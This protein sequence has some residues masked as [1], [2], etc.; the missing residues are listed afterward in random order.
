MKDL[1]ETV[2]ETSRQLK[3]D[4]RQL[5]ESI[6]ATNK[7]LAAS[8]ADLDDK[9]SKWGINYGSIAE[10]YFI[11]SFKHGK[12]N[13][14]GENFDDILVRAPGIKI[15]TDY[16]LA[17]LNGKS[18]AIIEVKYKA[19]KNDIPE[20]LKKAKSFRINYPDFANHKIYLGLASFAFY[21][22][23]EQAC[24]DN[25]IA[26][27]KQVGDTVVINDEHLKVY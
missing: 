4:S 27:I 2:A 20:V 9:I 21:D 10:E 5:K 22:I 7:A 16:D 24:T 26:I 3:E 13:F 25:G 11:N 23:L 15:K 6:A 18:V 19:H 1:K 8:T 14:F 12:R 17:L